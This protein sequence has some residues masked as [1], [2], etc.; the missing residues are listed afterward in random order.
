MCG[1][2]MVERP[3]AS[4][5]IREIS[6]WTGLSRRPLVVLSTTAPGV[7]RKVHDFYLVVWIIHS[8]DKVMMVIKTTIFLGD[9]VVVDEKWGSGIA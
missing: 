2:S 4:G 7:R 6:S 8:D 9:S 5:Q 1:K 3:I